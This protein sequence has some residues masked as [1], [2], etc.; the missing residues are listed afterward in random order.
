M[1]WSPEF[2]PDVS[3]FLLARNEFVSRTSAFPMGILQRSLK[4]LLYMG[5]VVINDSHWWNSLVPGGDRATWGAKVE[6]QTAR[7][8]ADY[9]IF[10]S[11]NPFSFKYIAIFVR[12]EVFLIQF[13]FLLEQKDKI[14]QRYQSMW[15][16]KTCW[17]DLK[18]SWWCCRSYAKISDA[19]LDA[20]P[21]LE[22]DVS[23][24][25]WEVSLLCK[26]RSFAWRKWDSWP[27]FPWELPT[28]DVCV[29]L[30]PCGRPGG[31]HD[32]RYMIILSLHNVQQFHFLQM[33]ATREDRRKFG[34]IGWNVAYD[35]NESDFKV[36]R[37]SS[38]VLAWH[39]HGSMFA[40]E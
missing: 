1:P 5:S 27:R 7:S 36:C 40:T 32:A 34:R 19:D 17:H 25:H 39:W 4:A 28:F 26:L 15:T 20:C 21:A 11:Q 38:S 13:C 10:E 31:V 37:D 3:S 14:T 2:S 6:H 12:G 22:K 30:L 24:K 18:H 16:P 29:G 23:P 8:L 33:T 35:F 9:R